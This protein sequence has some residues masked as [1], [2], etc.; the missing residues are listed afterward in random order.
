ML[1]KYL[2]FSAN[3]LVADEIFDGLDAL[4]CQRVIDLIM[5]S[6]SD[7]SSVYIVSHRDDMPIPYDKELIVVKSKDGISEIQ[8]L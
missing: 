5:T 1:C 7:I 8:A 3:I 6:L 2:N 4:G